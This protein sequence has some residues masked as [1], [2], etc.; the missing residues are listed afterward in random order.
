[1]LKTLYLV[2]AVALIG[3]ALYMMTQ[4]RT[5]SGNIAIM[6]CSIVGVSCVAMYFFVD[7]LKK[8]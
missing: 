2:F 4:P 6:L 5:E 3:G 1:M 7:K 8:Q